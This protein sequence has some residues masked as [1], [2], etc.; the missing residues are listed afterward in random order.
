MCSWPVSLTVFVSFS[1]L[2]QSCHREDD[3]DGKEQELETFEVN[4][5]SRIA[6]I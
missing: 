2:L 6:F 3:A 4:Y 5:S 1:V